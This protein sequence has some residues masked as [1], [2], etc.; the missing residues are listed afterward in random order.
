MKEDRTITQICKQCSEPYSPTRKGVQKFCSAS[1]RSRYW[2]LKHQDVPKP[3][4][5]LL[6]QVVGTKEQKPQEIKEEKPISVEKMSFSGVGNAAAGALLADGLKGIA[7][8]FQTEHNKPATKGDIEELFKTLSK[9][10]FPVVNVSDQYG[11]KAFYD[12]EMFK[13]V[14]YNEQMRRFELPIMDL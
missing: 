8:A 14:F 6:K 3:K 2:F 7:K 4:K 13:I 1:C 12:K 11:N 10:Y 5:D 9:R